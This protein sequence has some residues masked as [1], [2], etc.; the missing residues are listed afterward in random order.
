M[1]VFDVIIN[2]ADRKGGHVLAGIDGRVYGVDHGVSLHVR[3]KL[4]TVLWG[5][6]AEPIDDETL[7]DLDDLLGWLGSGV[8]CPVAGSSH[9]RGD[10][11]P[12][13]A[14]AQASGR[15]ADARPKRAPPVAVACV[16]VCRRYQSGGLLRSQSGH[17]EVSVDLTL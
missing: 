6:S 5:W 17:P 1:A 16:P 11:G 7:A 12:S 14:G 13:A 4:R 9:R 3:D 10:H 15:T 2:N 8:G